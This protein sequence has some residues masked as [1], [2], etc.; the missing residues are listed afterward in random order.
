MNIYLHN[1]I[2]ICVYIAHEHI[3]LTPSTPYA[4]MNVRVD[5]EVFK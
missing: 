1:H 3:H 2:F 4:V 5:A